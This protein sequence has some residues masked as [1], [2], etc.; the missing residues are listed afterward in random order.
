MKIDLI[1]LS[2]LKESNLRLEG[3]FHLSSDAKNFR[4]L[5]KAA[6]PL[7]LLANFGEIFNPPV[8]KRQFCNKTERSTPYRKSHDIIRTYED[9]ELFLPKKQVD[10]CNLAVRQNWILITGFGTDVGFAGIT[11][12]LFDGS[13]FANN[14][15]R[16]IPNNSV[17]FGYITAFLLSKFGKS[18][19]NKNASGSAI[20]YIEAPGIKKTLIPLLPENKQ[21]EIHKLITDSVSL[22]V[23]AEKSLKEAVGY[24]DA[25]GINYKYGSYTSRVIPISKVNLEK[26]RF[27]ANYT[28]V[29][30]LVLNTIK[31]GFIEYTTISS[32][33]KD[34][35]IGPRSKRNYVKKGVPFLSTAAIQRV[36]PTKV[37]KFISKKAA[38]GFLVKEGWILTTRSGTL[39]DTIYVLPSLDNYAVSEDA[40]R[41]VLKEESNITSGYLYAFLKSDLGKSSLL[42]GAY[43]SIIQHLNETYIGEVK[44]P[45]LDIEK[46]LEIEK[47]IKSHIEAYD[48]AIKYENQAVE[49]IE[50]EIESWQ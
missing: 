25:L 40:I 27:D 5:R 10:K 39:G 7:K 33:A 14:V 45:I 37:D 9:S 49:I 34:I 21:D 11:T 23:N 32:L 4:V 30:D 12:E 15:C 18:Q 24:F 41:I 29:S 36:N 46:R 35:F 47:K 3:R 28:V 1:K 13:A 31:E 38:D 43:G 16:I 42:S 6:F 17:P 22:R 48:Q 19:I 20:R 8:F 2:E 26:K 44:V 50:Q